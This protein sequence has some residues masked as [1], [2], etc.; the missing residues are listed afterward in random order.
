MD[1]KQVIGELTA[2][3]Y[4]QPEI[5]EQCDCG[6]ATVSDLATGKTTNPKFNTAQALLALRDRARKE[7][8]RKARAA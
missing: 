4:T 6:Q 5:A 1:W 3:G 7:A 2:H 8:K